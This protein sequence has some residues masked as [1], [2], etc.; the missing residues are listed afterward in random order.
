[1][2]RYMETAAQLR[3]EVESFI[4]LYVKVDSAL[5]TMSEELAREAAVKLGHIVNLAVRCNPRQAQGTVRKN[6]VQEA[7]KAYCNV[8][9]T[10]EHD[11]ATDREYNK[12]HI[13]PKG[14]K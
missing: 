13:T 4:N 12:I 6:I 3:K 7:V 1:M 5:P 14:G 11:E 2:A 10:R 8:T 9:M